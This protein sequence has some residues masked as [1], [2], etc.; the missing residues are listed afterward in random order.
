MCVYELTS[1]I[2]NLCHCLFTKGNPVFQAR[3]LYAELWRL[4]GQK[5]RHDSLVFKVCFW[6]FWFDNF[7]IWILEVSFYS[8]FLNIAIVFPSV[9]CFFPLPFLFQKLWTQSNSL[10]MGYLSLLLF[11]LHLCIFPLVVLVTWILAFLHLSM[12]LLN[13]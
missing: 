10:M 1:V 8:M 13:S 4:V 7:S 6:L 3:L 5:H 11:P 9:C 12:I 2:S